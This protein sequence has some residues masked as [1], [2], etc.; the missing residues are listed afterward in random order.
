MLRVPF[1]GILKRLYKGSIIGFDIGAVIIRIGFWGPLYDEYIIRTPP[2][3]KK[4]N[5]LITSTLIP[6]W[7]RRSW[8]I[9]DEIA[10]GL[11]AYIQV[12]VLRDLIKLDY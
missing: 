12:A 4:S 5:S 6:V 10:Q 8:E 11:W 3:Q 9:N 7:A 1:K 2:S